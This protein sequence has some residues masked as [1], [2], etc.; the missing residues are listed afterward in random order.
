M[1]HCEE[2]AVEEGVSDITFITSI[3]LHRF[4]RPDEFRHICGKRLFNKYYPQGR[5]F[6]YNAVD[7]EHSKRIV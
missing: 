1:E 2:I 6:N 3:A 4:I 7:K 5:M